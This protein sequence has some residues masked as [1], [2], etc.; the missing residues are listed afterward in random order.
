MGGR[1]EKGLKSLPFSRTDVIDN[2]K[3]RKLFHENLMQKNLQ[4]PQLTEV[5]SDTIFSS[6]LCLF[7]S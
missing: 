6:G 7:N 2:Q 5:E 4:L 1:G 3:V